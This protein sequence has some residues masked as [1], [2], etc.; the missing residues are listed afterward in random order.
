MSAS[1]RNASVERDANMM[2]MMVVVRFRV[3]IQVFES[4]D[5]FTC[6]VLE[7]SDGPELSCGVQLGKV[8]LQAFFRLHIPF[9]IL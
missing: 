9:G 5:D 3:H 4:R 1:A 6:Q 8:G 2:I 7:K